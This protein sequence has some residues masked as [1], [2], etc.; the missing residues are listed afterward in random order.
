MK[1]IF[2]NIELGYITE[3]KGQAPKFVD[4]VHG[5]RIVSL[6]CVPPS[7]EKADGVLT[8]KREF[9]ISIFTADCLPLLFFSQKEN[10]PIAAIHCG[11]RGALAQIAKNAVNK[12]S[13]PELE[14][15]LGPCLLP[16]CFEVKEDFI[17]LFKEQGQRVDSYLEKRNEKLYFDI[18]KYTIETQLTGV[19]IHKDFVRCTYCS[20]PEL[21]SYRRNRSTDPRIRSWITQH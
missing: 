3:P 4:Q 16:C 12:L 10:T 14:V 19:T 15:M 9:P 13:S 1:K 18:V 20:S 8:T 11:W 6:D 2:G 17:Q 5:D 7:L 21:P